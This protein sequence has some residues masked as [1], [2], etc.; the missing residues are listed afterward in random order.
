MANVR[1]SRIGEEIKKVLSEIIRELK[2]PRISSMT[3]IMSVDI[4]SDLN[5]AKIKVSVYDQ[6]EQARSD[7]VLALN[8]AAGFLSRELGRR[9]EIRRLPQLR[10]ILDN[11]IEYSV[12]ISKIINEINH[13]KEERSDE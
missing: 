9:M 1:Y 2:D 3:T 11:T 5:L 13:P 6:N 8:H 4:S 12:H 10:F 7:S